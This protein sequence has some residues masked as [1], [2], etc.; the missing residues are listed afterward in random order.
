MSANHLQDSDISHHRLYNHLEKEAIMTPEQRGGKK[1]CYG[2]K[3]Q[4]DDQQCY[5][6]NCKK[7]KKNLSTAWIDYK[8]AFDSVSHSWILKCLQ[9]YKIHP[10]LITFIEESM[11][12]WKTNMTL[13]HKEGVLETGPI[14]IKRG[15][16]Q[17]DSL[18]SLLFTMSL[19]SL[20]QELQKT[21]YGYQLDEQTKINHL[22]YVDDMK[23]Y[24]TSDKQLTGLINTVKNVSDDIKMEFGLDKCEKASFKRGKKVSAEGIPL[25]DN[26]VIQYLDL[27]ETYKYLG[28]QGGEG[29]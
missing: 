23:L 5:L 14:R 13:V 26:Q 20:S 29:V 2:C 28:M 7:R 4:L 19:N 6:R 9:M 24:G 27:A 17:G 25:N 10:V 15:I 8:R 18:S 12:Q 16:L 3:D 1:D 22:F 21:G 11:S